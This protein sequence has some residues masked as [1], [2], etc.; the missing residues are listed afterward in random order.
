MIENFTYYNIT[1]EVEKERLVKYHVYQRN[2]ALEEDDGYSLKGLVGM[3]AGLRVSN[4]SP[5]QTEKEALEYLY[6]AHFKGTLSVA[7]PYYGTI[8]KPMSE[9]DEELW[10]EYLATYDKH[11]EY[12]EQFFLEM[13][14]AK[15]NT[16]G[17]KHCKSS[18]PRELLKDMTCPCC[19]GLLYSPT[20]LKRV[21]NHEL[22]MKR[23]RGKILSKMKYKQEE[24]V[25]WV[26]GGH[27]AYTFKKDEENINVE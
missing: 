16:I 25:C 23:L 11:K 27:S 7:V 9:K 19:G 6:E 15:S 3:D 1:F 2:K 14:T 18:F 24:G 17:C 26:I 22:K 10:A 8:R 20:N 5:F 13:K 4:A 21:Q 12:Q